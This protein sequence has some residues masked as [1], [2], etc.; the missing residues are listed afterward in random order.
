MASIGSVVASS[1]GCATLPASTRAPPPGVDLG[2]GEGMTALRGLHGVDDPNSP[3]AGP[4]RLLPASLREARFWGAEPNG[5]A[6]GIVAGLR[7]VADPDGALDA[8]VNRLPGPAS[9]VA[10]LPERLGGGFLF[11]VGAQLWRSD[12]WLG[13]ATP[14]FASPSSG[15]PIGSILVGLDRAY[16]RYAPG[17]LLA[18]DPR[19]GEPLDLGPLPDSPRFGGIAALDAW[20]A[21]VVADLRGALVTSDAGASWHPT[22]LPIPPTEV[23]SLDGVYGAGALD[24]RGHIQWWLVRPDGQSEW[25]SSLASL[26]A[27]ARP[28]SARL[29]ATPASESGPQPVDPRDAMRRILL[30]RPLVAA[31]V[32]GW[33][34]SDGTAM[35]A[36]G[37]AL[38]RVRL[39]DG[40]VLDAVMDA[41]PLAPS[42]CHGV[43]LA[44]RDSRNAFGFVCGEPRGQTRIYAWDPASAHLVELRRFDDAREVVGCGN[45]ALVV[46]GGCGA[47]AQDRVPAGERAWCI[48]G[49]DRTWREIR[50][51]AS[52]TV[53][54]D[55]VDR[56]QLVVL[57]D[58][59]SVLVH[60]PIRGDL[61]TARLT[62]ANPGQSSSRTVPVQLPPLPVNE[63]DVLRLGTWMEGFEE[64]RPGV[65]GGWIDAGDVILGIEIDVD[66]QARVGEYIRDAGSPIVSGRWAFGWTPSRRGFESIDGGMTWAKMISLPEP[67]AEPEVDRERGCGRIGCVVAGW[68]RVGWGGS[69][70]PA[71]P[72]PPPLRA[73]PLTPVPPAPLHLR[74]EATAPMPSIAVSAPPLSTLR[75]TAAGLHPTSPGRWANGDTW[76]AVSDFPSFSGRAG[77]ELTGDTLGLTVEASVGARPLGRLYAWGPSTGEWDSMG[78]WQVRWDWA[79]GGWTDARSSAISPSP[80]STLDGA[81]HGL[82]IGPGSP[83]G[84]AIVPGDDPDHALL[85]SRPGS[86][87]AGAL[88]TVLE[89][90]RPP[91]P[92]QRGGDDSWPELQGA[93]R[94]G[95]R[96]F[97]L[98]SEDPGE[99]PAAVLSTID[100]GG[101]AREWL[102]IPRAGFDARAD[103]HLARQDD[104]RAIG[105]VAEGRPDA[106][107]PPSSWLVSVDL[108]TRAISDPSPLAPLSALRRGTEICGADDPGWALDEFYPGTV[109]IDVGDRWR[110][111]LQATR[112][113]VR[114]SRDRACIDGISGSVDP[115]ATAAPDVLAAAGSI[116]RPVRQPDRP[117]S[118]LPVSIFS[119]R[120]RFALRCGVP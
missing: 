31:I 35:V 39:S 34:L 14:V 114:L 56:T 79:W 36:R 40:R 113:R 112:A 66:G 102:R 29:P 55:G 22:T 100:L 110:S 15:A 71:P 19:R 92:V 76:G 59:R 108:E 87:S 54:S 53:P 51:A 16:L 4:A 25:V 96:W 83:V 38:A 63:R 99:P 60:P 68:L 62:V 105:F 73:A 17:S 26:A 118:V 94:T 18:I 70:S 77:P 21:L 7:V 115:F 5:G 23:L 12:D 116:A 97:V 50:T 119:A 48:L 95:G 41:F 90:N 3:A 57:A 86:G 6:R 13:Q 32:D 93:L 80:W 20:R 10:A 107:H 104:G 98:T 47:V 89:S 64:R 9:N 46:S 61:T 30:E 43:S 74:C 72:L 28:G 117:S 101:R 37:G 49:S 42:R 81:R 85:V 84:W 58:D 24:E 109:E 33:P 27:A 11:A 67:I 78:R 69:E 91:L 52:T 75:V 106:S 8:A 82:G 1:T 88:L 103:L 2:A 65:V 111:T 44:R 45:G 120:T